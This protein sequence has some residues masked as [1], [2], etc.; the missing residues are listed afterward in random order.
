LGSGVNLDKKKSD[1]GDSELENGDFI[2][3]C[4]W[5]LKW[6]QLSSPWNNCL[7]QYSEACF[8]IYFTASIDGVGL[9]EQNSQSKPISAEA[10]GRQEGKHEIMKKTICC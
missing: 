4:A 8:P 1:L 3:R 2:G 9:V 6:W 7:G 5:I 10:D